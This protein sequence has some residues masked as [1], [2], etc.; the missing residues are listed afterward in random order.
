V[1]LLKKNHSAIEQVMSLTPGGMHDGRDNIL[2]LLGILGN[3]QDSLSVFHVTGSNGKGSVCQ[4]IAQV[5]SKQFHKK[6]GLF[7]SPHLIDITER[8]QIH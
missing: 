6:V 5:L 7:T 8:F 4:M 2:K 1:E 3:P